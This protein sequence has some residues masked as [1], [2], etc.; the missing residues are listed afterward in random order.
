MDGD[1][2]ICTKQASSSSSNAN[3]NRSSAFLSRLWVSK[4]HPKILQ[5]HPKLWK[6]RYGFALYWSKTNWGKHIFLHVAIATDGCNVIGRHNFLSQNLEANIV[7]F[8]SAPP[9]FGLLLYCRRFVQCGVRN[10]KSCNYRLAWRCIRLQWRQKV[11]SCSAH[12]KQGGCRVRE[13]W[14]QGVTFWLFG[15]HWS[16]C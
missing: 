13:Q 2:D 11:G 5:W 7:S 10:C 12:T 9:H 15:P 16:S 1:T 6:P 8:V 3:R 4:W 14:E